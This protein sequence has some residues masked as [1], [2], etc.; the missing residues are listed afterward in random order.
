MRADKSSLGLFD[1]ISMVQMW[2]AVEGDLA[3]PT[4]SELSTY[5]VVPVWVKS[6]PRLIQKININKNDKNK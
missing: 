2:H 1:Q 5:L 3:G 4:E 6:R